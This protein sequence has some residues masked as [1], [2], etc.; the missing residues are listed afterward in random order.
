[1][2]KKRTYEEIEEMVLMGRE[3]EFKY[4]DVEY[5]IG[6]FEKA[7]LVNCTANTEE[8]FENQKRLLED[9]RIE[10]KSLKEIFDDIVTGYIF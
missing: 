9:A 7:T 8:Y 10:G 2:R 4:K 6:N 1:M 5:F 3:V